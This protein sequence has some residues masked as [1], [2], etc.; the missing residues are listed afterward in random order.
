[1]GLI[2]RGEYANPQMVELELEA[3]DARLQALERVS[4]AATAPDATA[5][6]IGRTLTAA[7]S[8]S[9]FTNQ[10]AAGAI[11]IVLSSAIIGDTVRFYVATAQTLTLTASA[12]DTMR[13]ADNTTAEGGS[14]SSNVVGSLVWFQ[15][16][17]DREWVAVQSV[18]S[19]TF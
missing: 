11:T 16:V 17:N 9:L 2:Y 18:G 10:G 14:I 7:D 12:G 19:W 13:I 3:L 5:V 4:A 1:M 6:T 8:G 15:A